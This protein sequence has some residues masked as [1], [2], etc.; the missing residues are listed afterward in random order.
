M[1]FKKYVYNKS[2]CNNIEDSNSSNNYLDIEAIEGDTSVSCIR[3]Y[4]HKDDYTKEI[5]RVYIENGKL[6]ACKKT[7]TGKWLAKSL[8]KECINA[9]IRNALNSEEKAGSINEDIISQGNFDMKA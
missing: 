7:N 6:Y 8:K 5:I 1:P 4:E 3:V 9:Y 2:D